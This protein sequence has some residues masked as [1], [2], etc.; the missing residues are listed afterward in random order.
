MLTWISCNHQWQARSCG[1]FQVKQIKPGAKSGIL[2][3]CCRE[4]T[5]CSQ[6]PGCWRYMLII[7]NIL[8]IIFLSGFS[9][10][11]VH[12]YQGGWLAPT[13]WDVNA[14]SHHWWL[15][16]F[17]VGRPNIRLIFQVL[18]IRAPPTLFHLSYAR[19]ICCPF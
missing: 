16:E 3:S 1:L 19:T 13:P 4:R 11:M 12:V 17:W 9:I 10:M 5:W 6:A 7:L 2:I 8:L 14:S 15:S 18:H